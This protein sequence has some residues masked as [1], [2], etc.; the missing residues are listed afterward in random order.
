MSINVNDQPFGNGITATPV[1]MPE[2]LRP[3]GPLETRIR[4]FDGAGAGWQQQRLQTELLIYLEQCRNLWTTKMARP[5]MTADE[6]LFGAV[7]QYEMG[8]AGRVAAYTILEMECPARLPQYIPDLIARQYGA[9]RA[10]YEAILGDMVSRRLAEAATYIV[11][12]DGY[13][14]DPLN[15][16][17]DFTNVDD[18][19]IYDKVRRHRLRS[20]EK[21]RGIATGISPLDDATGGIQGLCVIGGPA[22]AGKSSL[23]QHI[24]LAALMASPSTALISHQLDMGKGT[25]FN[26][27]ACALGGITERDLRDPHLPP[28]RQKMV[29]DAM[30]AVRAIAARIDIVRHPPGVQPDVHKL[31]ERRNKFLAAR[32]CD[33]AV[34][35][36]DYMQL[37]FVPDDVRDPVEADKRRVGFI[38][39]LQN[40]QIHVGAKPDVML[41]VSETRK[42]EGNAP[43]GL[44]DLLGSSRI[45]YAP[46]TVLLLQPQ[47]ETQC[48][49]DSAP[50]DLI[51]AKSRGGRKT[52]IRLMFDFL[53]YRFRAG[54]VPRQDAVP[55]A[56]AAGKRR[57]ASKARNPLG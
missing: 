23:A 21:P 37:L 7:Y 24:G 56:P 11:R 52:T 48:I 38:Q 32:G 49:G 31:I 20:T 50:V 12:F 22:G 16:T 2:A 41:V 19:D 4:S 8:D 28:D 54:D 40:S 15:G 17:P 1:P 30:A 27:L 44:S 51:V 14:A 43:L 47:A 18:F 26:R 25:C 53:T 46:D 34:V 39:T 35:I 10:H 13:H 29:D 36:V 3:D 9:N 5:G 45:G 57:R 6:A 42:T 55:P 33:R